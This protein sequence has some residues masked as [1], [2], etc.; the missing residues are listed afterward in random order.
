MLSLTKK[1][2]T[3]LTEKTVVASENI[4][5]SEEFDKG[6]KNLDGMKEAVVTICRKDLDNFE[7]QSTVSTGWF[8]INNEWLNVFYTLEPDFYN[9]FEKDIEGQYMEPY[10]TFLV[11][12]DTTKLKLL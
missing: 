12:F 3:P 6:T 8:N 10:K 5:T 11:P 9:F 7:G 1:K 2:V 4:T